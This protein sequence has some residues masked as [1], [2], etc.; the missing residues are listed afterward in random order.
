MDLL[1][2]RRIIPAITARRNT[3]NVAKTGTVVNFEFQPE[4]CLFNIDPIILAN[5]FTD[6]SLLI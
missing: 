4:N 5:S 3:L 6:V 1:N 2:A